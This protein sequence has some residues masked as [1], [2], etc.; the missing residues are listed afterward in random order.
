MKD[1]IR[2]TGQEGRQYLV[3]KFVYFEILDNIL[4]NRPATQPKV[5]IDS[6][7]KK[8]DHEGESIVS[9]S[10]KD[11]ELDESDY[12]DNSSTCMET[13]STATVN[14]SSDCDDKESDTKPPNIKPHDEIKTVV[15][16]KKK[17]KRQIDVMQDAM[18][19]MVKEVLDAQKASDKL[20]AE[21]EEKRMRMEEA[22]QER[23]SRMRREDQEFQM[24]VLRMLTGSYLPQPP[25]DMF[26]PYPGNN[27]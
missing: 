25:V 20:F 13:S 7:G 4:G 23:E 19:G 11:G 2:Q 26:P 6:L 8:S 24:R 16:N 9:D 27:P 10:D 12:M 14:A 1:K 22:Q 18:K 17:R 21:L 3:S 5:I 15:S